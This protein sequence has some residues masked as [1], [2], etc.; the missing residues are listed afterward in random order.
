MGTL[1]KIVGFV[2][3]NAR[4]LLATV[5]AIGLLGAAAYNYEYKDKNVGM[6]MV[7]GAA[8]VAA[9]YTRSKYD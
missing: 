7:A 5:G 4:G 6:A 2:S 9:A 8:I 3:N 1:E